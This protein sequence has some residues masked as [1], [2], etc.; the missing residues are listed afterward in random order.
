MTSYPIIYADQNPHTGFL[1]FKCP[2]CGRMNRHGRGEGHRASH[3]GCWPD[4]YILRAKG[5]V[6]QITP[7]LQG[8]VVK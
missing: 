8:E 4:G 7:H 3:C 2:V 5:G 6:P 1:S